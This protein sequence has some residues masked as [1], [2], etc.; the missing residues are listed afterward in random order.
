MRDVS[1]RSHRSG[2]VTLVQLAP[3]HAFPGYA[4]AAGRR[5]STTAGQRLSILAP[6]CSPMYSATVR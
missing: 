1:D 6:D 4:H 2:P 5:Y 3:C